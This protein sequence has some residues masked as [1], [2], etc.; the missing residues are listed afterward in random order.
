M[1]GVLAMSRRQHSVKRTTENKSVQYERDVFWY[2]T[3]IG[4]YADMIMGQL[5]KV[6]DTLHR[7]RA[8][9]DLIYRN[10][11]D[12]EAWAWAMRHV[13]DGHSEIIHFLVDVV[14]GLERVSRIAK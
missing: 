8:N 10:N 3:E 6:D 1:M 7:Y 14:H 5:Q 11:E 2:S 12:R 13:D 4:M 9:V